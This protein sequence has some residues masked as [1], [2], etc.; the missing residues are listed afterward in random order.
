[1]AIDNALEK[2]RNI[3]N[4]DDSELLGSLLQAGG[5]VLAGNCGSRRT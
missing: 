4:E 5:F 2:I 3:P 1:M